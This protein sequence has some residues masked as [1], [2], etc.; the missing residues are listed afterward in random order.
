VHSPVGEHASDVVASH[1]THAFPPNPHVSG[2]RDLH[3]A[4]EQHPA[5]QLAAQSEQTPAE[6]VSPAAQSEHRCPA[7]PQAVVS[8]PA[9]HAPVLSQHPAQELGSHVH[10]PALQC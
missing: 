3:S 10:A 2:L 1:A 6:Q 5:G 9:W 7:D 8:P 4:P